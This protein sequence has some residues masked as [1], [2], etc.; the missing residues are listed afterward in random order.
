MFV[1]RER[2]RLDSTLFKY[3]DSVSKQL[4]RQSLLCLCLLRHPD[5]H[6]FISQLK[7][8][9]FTEFHRAILFGVSFLLRYSLIRATGVTLTLCPRILA[10]ATL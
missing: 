8:A 3:F 2:E 4:E 10:L 9:F 6:W 7:L 5:D 1:H